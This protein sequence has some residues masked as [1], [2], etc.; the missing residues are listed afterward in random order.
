[1]IGSAIGTAVKIAAGA[2]LA[3]T[4]VHAYRE[5]KTH[6]NYYGVPFDFR[7]PSAEKARRLLWNPDDPRVFTPPLF[8]AGWSINFYQAVQQMREAAPEDDDD[9][10]IGGIG[11]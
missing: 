8:G 5:G 1:M 6:G 11:G 2:A 10:P 7:V 9:N 4:A 3:A